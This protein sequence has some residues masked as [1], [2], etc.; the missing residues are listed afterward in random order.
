MKIYITIWS[1]SD[2][3]TYSAD[4]ITG[5]W[6]SKDHAETWVIKNLDN[7]EYKPGSDDCELRIDEYE[8]DKE[9]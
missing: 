3:C 6:S 9:V 4:H 5:I 2:G 7:P 1:E 8:I